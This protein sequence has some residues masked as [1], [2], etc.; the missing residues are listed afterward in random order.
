[1]KR[2]A[3]IAAAFA[4]LVALFAAIP[5]T[6]SAIPR[7]VV[8][9]RG[10]VW[11]NYVQSRNASGVPTAYGVPYSQRLYARANGSSV[12]THSALGWRTDCSGFVSMCLGLTYKSGA[13]LSY[14]TA[15][16]ASAPT[17]YYPITAG[18]LVPGDMMLAAAKWGAGSPHVALFC[19]WASANHTSYWALEQTS[20]STHN[21][22]IYH[23]RSYPGSKYYRPY[24]FKGIEDDFADVLA[25]VQ[26]ADRFQVAVAGSQAAYPASTT[27]SVPALVVANGLNWPDAL[28]GSALAGAAGGPMLLTLPSMLPASTAAEIAR[29]KPK[30]VYV[31]GGTASVTASVTAQIAK[32]GAKVVRLGGADRYQTAALAASQTAALLRAK[33]KSVSVMFLATGG[34]FPDALAASPIA[35]KLGRPVLLTDPF[36]LSAA[37]KH[38]IAALKVKKIVI[39]GGTSS[40]T[41]AVV[42]ALTGMG[43]TTMRLS[44]PDRYVCAATIANYGVSQGLAWPGT[45]VASGA[46]FADALSG[47]VTQGRLNAVLLL[48]PPPAVPKSVI[49]VVAA[50]KTAI[51]DA[52]VFGGYASVSYAARKQIAAVLRVK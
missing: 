41:P 14:D 52:R 44:G 5:A 6:A 20:S 37:T 34:T 25:S 33:G 15:S 35:A 38:E 18:E 11:A 32:Y 8:I 51:G 1:M 13:P 36:T 24:R 42:T 50:H 47:G 22:T 28:G 19:G 17:S 9:A 45:G 26:G 16:F 39:L 21:G 40:V 29:L 46:G 12:G 30:T 48:T 7:D 43:C 10:M 23:V 49:N 31:L 2:T 3:V 27:A 4:T